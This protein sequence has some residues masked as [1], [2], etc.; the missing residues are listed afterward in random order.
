VMNVPVQF[1]FIKDASVREPPRT[2]AKKPQRLY[3]P[4]IENA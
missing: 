1:G 3:A 4:K 2:K